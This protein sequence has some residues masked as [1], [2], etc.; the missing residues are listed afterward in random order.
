M[1]SNPFPPL[2]VP[3]PLENTHTPEVL[4]NFGVLFPL[5]LQAATCENNSAIKCS[6]QQPTQ[7]IPNISFFKSFRRNPADALDIIRCGW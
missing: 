5:S 3:H 2:A 6:W 1:N 4:Y 7:P